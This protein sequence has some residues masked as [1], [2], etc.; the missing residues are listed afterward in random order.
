MRKISDSAS[1]FESS[2]SSSSS[3]AAE[4]EAA[5]ALQW[6]TERPIRF[7][8]GSRISALRRLENVRLLST[9]G[10]DS[11]SGMVYSFRK[12]DILNGS[13]KMNDMDRDAM[14]L[15]SVSGDFNLIGWLEAYLLCW[16]RLHVGPNNLI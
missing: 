16:Q 12:R 14:N 3:A 5:T 8:I 9:T 15:R 7:K 10:V 6:C 11:H 13:G 2:S 4:A 1:P